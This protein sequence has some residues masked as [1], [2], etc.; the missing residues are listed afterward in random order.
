[1]RAHP[2]ALRSDRDR[3]FTLV[4][5]LVT[6]TVTSIVLLAALLLL[7]GVNGNSERMRRVADTQ[8]NG[9]QALDML[10]SELRAAGMGAS[11]GHI[12]VA[13]AGGVLRRVP[14]IYS[15]PDRYI[16]SPNG[17]QI[18]SAS[19]FVI[20]AEPSSL[21][22]AADGTGMQGVV[23]SVKK[24]LPIQILCSTATGTVVQCDDASYGDATLVNSGA[25]TPIIVSDDFHWAVMI[26]PSGA[27]F[28]NPDG[29]GM[30]NEKLLSFV[31]QGAGS[32]EPDNKAPFG[33]GHAAH[34]L[35][36]RVTHWYLRQD[37]DGG[38][39]NLV[40]SRPDLRSTALTAAT[41]GGCDSTQSP[42]IDETNGGTAVG[43]SLGSGPVQ[44][45]R[46][47][48]MIG[49]IDGSEKPAE[50]VP[51]G[52]DA[53]HNDGGTVS[54]NQ[55]ERPISSCDMALGEQLREVRVAVVA[56][57][58]RPDPDRLAS[59][60]QYLVPLIDGVPIAFTND[61]GGNTPLSPADVTRLSDAYVLRTYQARVVPR[62]AYG[63]LP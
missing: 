51:S 27:L 13:P 6:T 7:Q 52:W 59:A 58:S 41:D 62:N 38:T 47:R 3:G 33:F 26:T 32:F 34:L 18:A 43:V 25:S 29:G 37:A 19:V 22:V 1:M 21:G 40:R 20:T 35:K 49:A 30:P 28:N 63:Y 16:S 14:V 39:V 10:E 15:E 9:R 60:G 54:Y 55:I 23:T 31:E 5:I 50:W 24:N 48:Y 46:L 57:A 11:R 17:A 12:G 8:T 36:A 44:G 2:P 4:E 56:Q 42:F 45:F 53:F 61:G